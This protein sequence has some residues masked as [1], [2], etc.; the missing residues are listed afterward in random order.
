MIANIF[1]GDLAFAWTLFEWWTFGSI[2]LDR[3]EP[4]T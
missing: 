2:G 1:L 4:G 3:L